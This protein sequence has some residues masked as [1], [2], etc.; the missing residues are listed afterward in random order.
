ML[1]QIWLISWKIT[2]IKLDF[3]LGKGT[4]QVNSSGSEDKLSDSLLLS[5]FLRIIRLLRL[6]FLKIRPIFLVSTHSNNNKPSIYVAIV[7]IMCTDRIAL[8]RKLD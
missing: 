6:S 1:W 2:R 8:F 7:F 5:G 3:C 4:Y